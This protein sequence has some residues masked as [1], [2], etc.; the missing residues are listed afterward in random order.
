[1]DTRSASPAQ[2]RRRDCRFC[3]GSGRVGRTGTVFAFER[4]RVVPDI[5]VLS[6]TLGAGLP[7]AAVVTTDQISQPS[8][9]RGFL[10]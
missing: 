7:L 6:K 2:I 8:D 4:D 10:F 1:L 3:A 9:D 5:L